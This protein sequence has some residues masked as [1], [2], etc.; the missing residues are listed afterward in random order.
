VGLTDFCRWR[1]SCSAHSQGDLLLLV[2]QAADSHELGAH[3]ELDNEVQLL[4]EAVYQE[5]WS[6]DGFPCLNS[7]FD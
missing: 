3:P 5:S 4:E 1:S 2:L 7:R 6:M